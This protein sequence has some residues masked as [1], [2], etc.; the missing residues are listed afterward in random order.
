MPE[1][2]QASPLAIM[3]R[4]NQKLFWGLNRIRG[5]IMHLDGLALFAFVLGSTVLYGQG[6]LRLLAVFMILSFLLINFSKFE[7]TLKR[8]R[9]V[10][11]ELRY[12]SAWVVWSGVTGV[13]VSINQVYFTEKFIVVLQMFLMIWV[14]YGIT[15]RIQNIEMIFYA[16]ILGSIIQ[17][18][19]GLGG[20]FDLATLA[21]E[22]ERVEG[23][24]QNANS[25]GFRMLWGIFSALLFWNKAGNWRPFRRIS[26]IGFIFI[27]SYALLATGS[28]KSTILLLIILVIWATYTLKHN[29]SVTDYL[30]RFFFI[31]LIIF[32]VLNIWS[33]IS[34]STTVGLRFNN[35]IEQGDGS[36]IRAIEAQD[37]YWMY[38]YGIKIFLKHPIFGVGLDNFRAHFY[39]G[40]SHSDYIAALANTGIIGF[41]LYQSYYIILIKRIVK[42]IKSEHNL[43]QLYRLKMILLGVIIIMLLGFGTPHYYSLITFTILVSFSSYTWILQRQ[44]T[45][46]QLH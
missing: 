39:G 6:Q 12:Y 15:R 17:I 28:R 41:I 34:E 8:L 40:M 16:Y 21:I 20:V 32:I 42:L 46:K 2:N 26:I 3:P 25:F 23:F 13:F 9:P 36:A 44:L 37:R 18:A 11:P 38:F 7:K 19:G 43:H 35:L 14:V 33:F 27:S 5:W 4:R 30:K 10:P 24:T 22:R 45:E 1:S 31:G 29:N